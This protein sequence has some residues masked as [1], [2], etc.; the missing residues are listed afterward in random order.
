LEGIKKQKQAKPQFFFREIE[1][2]HIAGANCAEAINNV[3]DDE[4][5]A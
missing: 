4:T 5:N 2:N 3:N 1:P